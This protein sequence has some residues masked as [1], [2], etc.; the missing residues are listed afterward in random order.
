MLQAASKA[1]RGVGRIMFDERC[2]TELK[3]RISAECVTG[4]RTT[5]V[6]R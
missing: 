5:C 1:R 4:K 2:D 6:V 3:S